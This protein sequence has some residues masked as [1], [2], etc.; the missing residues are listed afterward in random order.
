MAGRSASAQR[1]GLN[2]DLSVSELEHGGCSEFQTIKAICISLMVSSSFRFAAELHHVPCAGWC[3][4]AH[5]AQELRD[6]QPVLGR[7]FDQAC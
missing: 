7:H 4:L 3:C 2:V 6:A 5:L 1:A